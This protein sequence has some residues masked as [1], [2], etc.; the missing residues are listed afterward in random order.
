LKNKILL[1]AV[2]L[3]TTAAITSSV[4]GGSKY[5]YST[6][7]WSSITWYDAPSGGS[8]VAAPT[9][10]DDVYINDGVSVII[11][12]NVSIT[13]LTIGQGAT[14]NLSFDGTTGRTFT[15]SGN[16]IINTGGS[17]LVYSVISVTGDLTSGSTTINNLSSTAG[18]LS[19]MNVSGTGVGAGATVSSVGVNSMVVSVAS[20]ATAAGVT[21]TIKPSITNTLTI[22]GNLVNNGVFDMSLGSSTTICNVT[23]NKAGDQTISGAGTTTRFR[24]V[25]LTKTAIANKVICSVNVTQ[26]GGGSFLATGSTGTWEQSA[27][28]FTSSSASIVTGA[29]AGISITNTG[30]W[31]QTSTSLTINGTLNINTNGIVTIGGAGSS[32]KLDLTPA[33]SN[34]TISAGTININGKLAIASLGGTVNISGGTINIDPT[35]LVAGDY[36]FRVTNNGTLLTFSGGT[37]TILN[38]HPVASS[39]PEFNVTNG[40]KMTGTAKLVFGQGVST[41]SSPNGGFRL[42][43]A[44]L[45]FITDITINTGSTGLVLAANVTATKL[46]YISSGAITGGF[47]F[48]YNAS[49][50]LVYNGLSAQTTSD[51]EFPSVNGPANLTINNSAGVT[52]HAARNISGTL[53]LTNGK[54][55]LGS[56]DITAGALSGGSSSSY[57]MTNGTGG[58]KTNVPGTST[59][60][61]FPVGYTDTYT[62]VVVN[63][64]GTA[65]DFTVNVKNTFDNSPYTTQVVN[66]QWII[67]EGTPGGTDASLSFQWNTATDED[68]SFLR[69]GN[70]VIG[71]WNGSMWVDAD[72]AATDMGS[73]VYKASASGFTSFSPF[74]VGNMASLPVELSSFTSNVN[75][76]NITLSWETKTEKN[77]DKFV[78]EKMVGSLWTSIG[79]VKSS[80]MSN[81]PKQYSYTDK[82]LQA[83]KYQYRLKMIDNDGSYKY[84][85]VIEVEVALPKEFELS[86]N[87]PN[88]FNPSTKI[89]YSLPTSGQVKLQ[90]YSVNGELIKSLINEHQEAGYYSVDF[91]GVNLSSGIYIYRLSSGNNNIV[92]KMTLLK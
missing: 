6:G 9:A 30:N 4:F 15:A 59:N 11:D 52:L 85:S 51:I 37:I 87:Y 31:T 8:I 3:V 29:N 60:V 33:G 74:A 56:Y 82:N 84:S 76:S 69:T 22:G 39:M 79:S 73:G 40:F 12:Q 49:G 45:P 19:G 43:G 48:V 42:G 44:G 72:A 57:V 65:D 32:N 67:A 80:V 21:L 46:T 71:R 24:G 26:G 27:G 75:G 66:K 47:G 41:A 2:F 53:T 92:K 63:N 35:T 78:I 90:I 38:P 50:T 5:A 89:S 23:F 18:I 16:I 86:Q 55:K 25:T 10:G 68:A 58:L 36:P 88:P 77:S 14:G 62:P 81:S 70:V 20:T 1:I 28:T 13:N 83:S 61:L 34:T 91:S 17:F 64:S 7:N 54:L